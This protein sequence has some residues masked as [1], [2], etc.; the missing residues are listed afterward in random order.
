MLQI[1]CTTFLHSLLY[2][3]PGQTPFCTFRR[4][5]AITSNCQFS[6]AA[7]WPP[8]IAPER[9]SYD[10]LLPSMNYG[11]RKHE[12]GS[13]LSVLP[14][15]VPLRNRSAHG[16]FLPFCSPCCVLG[17]SR[18]VGEYVSL[19]LLARKHPLTTLYA[20]VGPMKPSRCTD[21][22]CFYFFFSQ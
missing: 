1:L 15:S 9:G 14:S 18:R 4:L 16:P 12:I 2:P 17:R 21:T 13:R 3:G 19:A 10:L 22:R 8:N 6:K 7:D 11:S 5:H 20:F